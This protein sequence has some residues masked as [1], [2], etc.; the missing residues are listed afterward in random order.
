MMS[1][2]EKIASE[3]FGTGLNCAQS[4]LGAFCN[5]YGIEQDTAFK[6]TCGL[7]SGVRSA[8]ICGAVSGAVLVIG[9]KY[10]E[11]KRICDI[12][13]EEFIKIW[14]KTLG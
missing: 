12:K 8:E 9:L 7:G 5:N 4:V 6:I 2:K 14:S 10:G 11:S 3:L 1:E 13:T